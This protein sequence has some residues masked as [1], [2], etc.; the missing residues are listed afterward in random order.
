MS[1][2]SKTPRLGANI[3]ALREKKNLSLAELSDRS[4]VPQGMLTQIEQE[5]KNPT[6][7]TVWK[8]AKALDFSLQGIIGELDEQERL[9]EILRKDDA[10]VLT[11]DDGSY[12]IRITSPVNMKDS[13]EMYHLVFKPGGALRSA[14]H[15]PGTEEFLTV[16]KGRLKIRSAK[17][18]AELF[19]GDSARY[20]A[21]VKHSI[22][23]DCSEEAEAF[24]VVQ[25]KQD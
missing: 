11:A 19:Y 10:P 1:N 12:T 14:P 13:L 22:E 25:F 21:D 8:I 24:L 15:Y 5:K 9:F 4:G 18:T 2:V 23:N 17:T 6:V 3:S 20:L 7:A 16:V